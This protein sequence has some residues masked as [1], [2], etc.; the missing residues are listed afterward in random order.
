MSAEAPASEPAAAP[1]AA[2]EP[3]G[4]PP[5]E[6][7]FSPELA[8][9]SEDLPRSDFSDALSN[10]TFGSATDTPTSSGNEALS[11]LPGVLGQLGEGLRAVLTSPARFMALVLVWA[12]MAAPVY[13]A[14]RRR[15]VVDHVL[16]TAQEIS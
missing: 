4:P 14:S 2:P 15:L 1:Q 11:P 9:Y 7:G 8:S 13:L 6:V 5:G 12:V 16:G 3:T 10:H